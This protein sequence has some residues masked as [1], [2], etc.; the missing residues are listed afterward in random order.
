MISKIT[1]AIKNT[2]ISVGKQDL[3]NIFKSRAFIHRSGSSY[4]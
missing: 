3:T 4:E 1:Q 2:V